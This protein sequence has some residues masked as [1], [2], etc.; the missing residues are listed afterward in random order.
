M[1]CSAT[2]LVCRTSLRETCGTTNEDRVTLQGKKTE[3]PHC[4]PAALPL[5]LL[6]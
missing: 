5:P 3:N 4:Q 6:L 2:E 1:A